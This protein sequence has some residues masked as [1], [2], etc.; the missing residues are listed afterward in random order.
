MYLMMP[1]KVKLEV[2]Y[3]THCRLVEE[4]KLELPRRR[5]R[6]YTSFDHLVEANLIEFS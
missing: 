6:S 2:H 4:Q 1:V 3:A 5:K